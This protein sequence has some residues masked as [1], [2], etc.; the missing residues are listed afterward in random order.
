[1]PNPTVDNNDEKKPL[2]D[3]P[4]CSFFL[5]VDVEVGALVFVVVVVVVVAVL[6]FCFFG[7]RFAL[8]SVGT[9]RNALSVTREDSRC[10][11]V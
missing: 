7:G 1:V 4:V 11:V 8:T 2:S 6:C 5:F 10:A 3:E 9:S